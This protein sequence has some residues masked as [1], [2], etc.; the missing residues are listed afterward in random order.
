MTGAFVSEQESLVYRL[1]HREGILSANLLIV[2]FFPVGLYQ[3]YQLVIGVR[4]D[5]L[6]ARTIDCLRHGYPSF[7]LE[8]VYN[9]AGNMSKLW[10]KFGR[11]W[12]S[13]FISQ[14]A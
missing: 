12:A 5:R 9:T 14:A 1:S 8:Y 10:Q 7:L 4:C 3:P 2:Y 13:G 6:P 11:S